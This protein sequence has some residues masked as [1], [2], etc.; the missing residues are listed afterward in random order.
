MPYF[1]YRIAP[2]RTLTLVRAFDRFP[3]AKEAA[4]A[5]RAT[6]ADG[7]Q[8]KIIFAGD[9]AEAEALLSTPRERQPSEDDPLPPSPSRR[10]R[11]K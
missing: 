3:E 11:G 10:G 2:E 5:L 1:I 6:A 8:W 4:R 9:P 7:E